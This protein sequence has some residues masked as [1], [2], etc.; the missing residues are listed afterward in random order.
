VNE[1]DEW[2]RTESAN[3][4]ARGFTTS[5]F[6][7]SKARALKKLNVKNVA[8]NIF[9]VQL[10]NAIDCGEKRI[11]SPPQS[12]VNNARLLYNHEIPLTCRVF[13]TKVS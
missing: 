3:A 10:L 1:F 4:S 11:V 7:H 5:L 12:K 6:Q 9:D 13:R 2:M 8:C